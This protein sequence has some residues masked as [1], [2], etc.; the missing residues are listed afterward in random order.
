MTDDIFR[1]IEVKDRRYR[2]VI[3]FAAFLT[4]LIL[5][6]ILILQYQQ[7]VSNQ[8]VIAAQDKTLST[9]VATAKVR[10]N[11]INQLQQHIDCVVELFQTKN[12]T[13]YVISDVEN[14]KIDNVTTGETKSSG[15]AAVTQSSAA[16]EVTTAPPSLKPTTTGA[17]PVATQ[18]ATSVNKT[19]AVPA[20]IVG[21]LGICVIK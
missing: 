8:K 12:R 5:I 20:C 4:A 11:Q 14:C 6:I 7:T 15:T 17:A 10:S 3:G 19:P 13:N 9:L 21:L 1:E 18:S 2:I 16:P